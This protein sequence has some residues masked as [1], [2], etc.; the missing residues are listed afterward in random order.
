MMKLFHK[1]RVASVPPPF[2]DI[3]HL[4]VFFK[5]LSS[6]TNNFYI[7]QSLILAGNET[8]ILNISLESI[9]YY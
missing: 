1:V 2:L 7:S 5:H 8:D 4:T 3:A 9:C 6:D